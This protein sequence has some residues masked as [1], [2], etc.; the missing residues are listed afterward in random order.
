MAPVAFGSD[1]PIAD[2]NPWHGIAT[3]MTRRIAN[4]NLVHP[5]RAF[6][7]HQALAAYLDGAAFAS[8]RED[9]LGKLLPGYA[10]EVIALDTDPFRAEPE[11][12]W[13]IEAAFVV[14]Q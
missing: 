1:Y 3:A 12:I 6:D 8:H 4:G 9:H 14:P 5:D 10:A 7:R 11:D 13:E 2:L